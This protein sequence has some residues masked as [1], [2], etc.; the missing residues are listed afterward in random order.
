MIVVD[1]I[2]DCDAAEFGIGVELSP[3][4]LLHFVVD[5]NTSQLWV[6]VEFAAFLLL[7]FI[8]DGNSSQLWTRVQLP[9]LRLLYNRVIDGN[10]SCVEAGRVQLSS[11]L[12]VRVSVRQSWF[13][14]QES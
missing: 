5:G 11:F 12:L 7:N 2:V 3:F 13:H 4:L 1:I 9:T 8:V 10:G 14:E 6:R